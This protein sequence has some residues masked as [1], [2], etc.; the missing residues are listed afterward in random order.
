MRGIKSKAAE[1]SKISGGALET[2]VLIIGAGPTGLMAA[3][4]LSRFGI[5]FIII[6]KKEGP[7]KESRAIL[8]T[9]RSLEIYQQMGVSEPAVTEGKKIN[10]F[11]LYSRGKPK[12]EVLI[13][14]V[15]NKLTEFNYML[16]FE[17]SKNETL[18][19][20]RL[21]SQGE[22]VHWNHELIKLREFKDQITAEIKNDVGQLT[23]RSKFLI[24]CDGASSPV[25]NQIDFSFRGGTY[26]QLFFV[27]DTIVSW[28]E[29]YDK[30]IIAPGD[31]NFCAFLPLYGN[32]HYRVIGTLPRKYK[33]QKSTSFKEIEETVKETAGIPISFGGINWYATYK[34]HHRKVDQF[35]KYNVF[36]AGDSAHIHSPAGGQGMNTGLQDAYNLCW[37]MA[38]VLKGQAN[39]SLLNTYNEERLPFA[40]WLLRFTDRS[41]QM[42]TSNYFL[43]K[44]I[45]KLGIQIAS[46]GTRFQGLRLRAFKTISQ[47]GYSYSN[48]SL[49]GNYSKQKLKF[50]AG[51]RFPYFPEDNIYDQLTNASF[52][53]VHI[54]SI[55]E[56]RSITLIEHFPFPVNVI[57]QQ[58]SDRWKSKGVKKELFILVRPDNYITATF[59]ILDQNDIVAYLK[60]YFDVKSEK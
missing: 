13:G 3:N 22:E 36:L 34:L 60:K 54:Q 42:M 40:R 57:K 12:V 7:T 35:R 55:S 2:D 26:E 1:T 51:D 4:Q 58:L 33:D 15:G 8:T 28:S 56:D 50:R 48:S 46:L 45:R 18:L 23:I 44:I 38:L 53:L 11:N 52:H 10:S 43:V 6:D 20:H 19:F 14:E 37:K 5:E 41:F 9:A 31:Q 25:R 21:Q 30:L 17:Q 47:I 24:A 49:N 39:V 29:E 59:D 16:A 32:N 27:A